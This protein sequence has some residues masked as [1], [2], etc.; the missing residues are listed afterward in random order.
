LD[1]PKLGIL[2]QV[3]KKIKGVNLNIHEKSVQLLE[4]LAN[5]IHE[6]EHKNLDPFFFSTKEVHL[7]EEW[8][9]QFMLEYRK[10]ICEY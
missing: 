5:S 8:I 10:A 4:K 6:R 7:T 1:F 2:Y 3:D 9:E